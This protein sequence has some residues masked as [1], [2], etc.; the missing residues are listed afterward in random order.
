[1]TGHHHL[2]AALSPTKFDESFANAVA[3]SGMIGQFCWT[4]A[5]QRIVPSGV[6]RGVKRPRFRFTSGRESGLLAAIRYTE[7]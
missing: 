3:E 1:M 5:F 7:E 2:V 6:P 4:E